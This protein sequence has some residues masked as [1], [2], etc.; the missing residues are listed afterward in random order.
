MRP[1][2]HRVPR[3]RVTAPGRW[4]EIAVVD[5]DDELV[6]V[7]LDHLRAGVAAG[8]R[9][10][11]LLQGWLAAHVREVLPGVEVL[12]NGP[13]APRGP[14]AVA[15]QLALLEEAR[16]QG[17]RLRLLGV[18]HPRTTR[19][20][21][22]RLRDEAAHDA[23]VSAPDLSS[24]CVYDRRTTPAE[25]LEAA[26]LTHTHVRTLDGPV[27]NAA[28]TTGHQFVAALGVPEEPLQ[29]SAPV[30]AVDDAPSLP[31]L[32]HQL[33]RA[34]R[35]RAGGRDREEDFHLAVSEIAANAFRHGGRPVSARLWAAPDRLVCAISDGGAGFT[36]VLAGYRPAHGE[37]L[38]R[39]GMGLW[40]ARKL[41]DHVDVHRTPA[42]LTVRLASAVG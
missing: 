21:D 29:R 33:G 3:A 10:V 4:H 16:A 6:A 5:T 23:L 27:P 14:D 15:A 26:L 19:G 40:L 24:L 39:G 9:T 36:G 7:V 22:E 31:E 34:L 28:H 13:T 12:E 32:R 20:W 35:G 11:A 17:R 25:V 1:A 38:S 30:F 37:D 42:G 41:C 2:H 18:V 8:E